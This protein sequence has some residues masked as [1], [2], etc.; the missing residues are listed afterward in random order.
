MFEGF[1]I[2]NHIIA[3][4][5]LI[6]IA[7]LGITSVKDEIHY[8]K[9]GNYYPAPEPEPIATTLLFILIA[10]IPLIFIIGGGMEIE[11][12]TYQNVQ[13]WSTD[14]NFP[15]VTELTRKY[16]HDKIITYDEYENI[17]DLY[18]KCVHEWNKKYGIKS[19]IP[20]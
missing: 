4:I 12:D 7:Y 11:E 10:L 14:K 19:K 17:R 3:I 16:M 15:E 20:Q 8:L 18:E 1:F 9:N 5:A 13:K 6:I 2:A